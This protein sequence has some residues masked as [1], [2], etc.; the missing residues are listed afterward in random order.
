MPQLAPSAYS[1]TG[2]ALTGRTLR[3]LL[4]ALEYQGFE[5]QSLATLGPRGKWTP[6][7]VE[8]FYG[9]DPAIFRDFAELVWYYS[10]GGID[11]A[12]IPSEVYDLIEPEEKGRVAI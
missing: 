3:L 5:T 10:A 2:R 1:R 4:A 11:T 9:I 12:S 8:H 6:E 7:T